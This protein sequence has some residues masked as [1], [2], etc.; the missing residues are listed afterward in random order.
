MTGFEKPLPATNL[1]VDQERH[2][3]RVYPSAV[4][5]WL[6]VVLYASPIL[7]AVLCVYLAWIAMAEEAVVCLL[8]AVGLT[9]LNFVLTRPCRYTITSDTLNIR[10]GLLSQSIELDRITDAEQSSSWRSG[11]ALSLKRVRVHFDKGNRLISPIDRERFIADL[12]RA[13]RHARETKQHDR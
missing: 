7:L 5:R 12:M 4:D 8:L 6:M 10:C 2:V 1:G 9:L 11:P 3:Q 13:V